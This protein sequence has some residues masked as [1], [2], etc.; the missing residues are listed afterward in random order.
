MG[1]IMRI[2]ITNYIFEA[3][4]SKTKNFK[5]SFALCGGYKT[6]TTSKQYVVIK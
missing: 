4:I 1:R 6:S 3:T 2:S 5:N